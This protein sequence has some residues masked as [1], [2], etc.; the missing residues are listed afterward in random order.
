MP[1]P[2]LGAFR[3]LYPE[4]EETFPQFPATQN[5][6]IEE[7]L[8]MAWFSL[9]RR[10]PAVSDEEDTAVA[11]GQRHLSRRAYLTIK[12]AAHHVEVSQPEFNPD[13][14]ETQGSGGASVGRSAAPRRDGYATTPHGR[15]YLLG[16]EE[17]DAEVNAAGSEKF[18]LI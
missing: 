5:L 16:L 9:S 14:A 18:V 8:S 2:D 3:D 1:Q 12:R 6:A 4:D 10:T 13:R 11:E 7:E 15:L 17:N